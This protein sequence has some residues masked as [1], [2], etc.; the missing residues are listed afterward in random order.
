[1]IDAYA[2]FGCS[3][4]TSVVIGDSVRVIID[5]AFSNC[6][7]L[8]SVYY[9][10]T[11]NDWSGIS[12][13]SFNSPLSTATCYYYSESQPSVAGNYWHYVNGLVALW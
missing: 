7:N 1:M 4:L 13:G 8:A 2:F 5:Y 9:K 10:G 3:S 6:S 12:V 11:A